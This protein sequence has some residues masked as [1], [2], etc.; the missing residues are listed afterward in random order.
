MAAA[1]PDDKL[2]EVRDRI[3]IVDLVG[4]YVGLRRSGKNYSAC[5]PFHEEKTPSFYVNPERRSYKCFGC[6][7]YGDGIAFV[8]NI[9]GMGFLEAVR[10]LAGLYGVLLPNSPSGEKA[11]EK[12]AERDEAFAIVRAAAEIF[13]ETLLRRPEGAAGRA[14]QQTRRLDDEIAETFRLGYGPS[15]SEGGWDFLARAL[16]ERKLSLPM[17]EK[18]GLVG[19]SERT[20]SYFDRFRGRLIF[21]IIQPGGSVI[22]FS[23]RVLP[24]HEG[25]G[26]REAPKY[27][28][29]SES[30]L[31]SK[32][33]TLFGLHAASPSIRQRGRAILVEGNV[34]VLSMHQKGFSETVAPLGT[35]LTAPQL[36]ILGRFTDTVILCFDGDKAG[37]KAAREAIPLVLDADM[38][39]RIV[40]LGDGDD[41]D[42]V[43]ADR[44]RNLFERPHAALEW[45]M[46]W[47]VRKGAAESPELQV[48]ALDTLV[49][50]LRKV[51]RDTARELY[52]DLA[53]KLLKIPRGRISSAVRGGREDPRWS[54]PP[55]SPMPA[56][57]AATPIAPLP[58]G[59]SELVMLLVDNP[60]L[61]GAAEELKALDALTDARLRSIADAVVAAALRGENPGEGELLELVDPR[62][63]RQLHDRVFAGEYRG[64]DLDVEALLHEFLAAARRERLKQ[65]RR[66]I[67]RAMAEAR[68]TGDLERLRALAQERIA[69]R[70]Q[71]EDFDLNPPNQPSAPA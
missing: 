50:L 28:N 49:P 32:S 20:G 27:I 21:P 46:R 45:L 9:E 24:D 61:A 18:L 37:R 68:A 29:S 39:A 7:V 4:R 16:A 40:I 11:A 64:T 25:E 71:F 52:V 66:D 44:L 36:K 33:K 1:I 62:E 6:G 60:H 57:A 65:A 3:D 58:R 59:Q 56:A 15:P 19:R 51:R 23:G 47:M 31:Y 42:S 69:L 22:G 8:M 34:D 12:A 43:D 55:P 54:P 5:C 14:Y 67:D 41:P 10:K 30:V 2:Q 63:H 17:A 53:A 38:D 26:D 70:R 48:R 13:R 35:A